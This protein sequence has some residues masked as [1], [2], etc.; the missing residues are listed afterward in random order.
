MAKIDRKKFADKALEIVIGKKPKDEG[1]DPADEKDDESEA[2]EPGKLGRMLASALKHN[3]YEA[4]EE[5]V[6]QITGCDE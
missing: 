2:K 1:L 4:I 3:D 6:R 5:A